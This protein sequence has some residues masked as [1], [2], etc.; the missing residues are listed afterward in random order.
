MNAEFEIEE[1]NIIQFGIGLGRKKGGLMLL[2]KKNDGEELAVS[3]RVEK[4]EEIRD[5]A[6]RVIR[7]F[8]LK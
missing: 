7:E 2:F 4:W 6:D 8:N 1:S 3:L 5:A